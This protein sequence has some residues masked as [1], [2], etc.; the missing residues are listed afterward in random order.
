MF[1]RWENFFCHLTAQTHTFVR[2]L[3]H[4]Q[5]IHFYAFMTAGHQQSNSW[6]GGGTSA[7]GI[8]LGLRV[9]VYRLYQQNA[10]YNKLWP[11][12]PQTLP[13]FTSK[14]AKLSF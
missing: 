7:F 11:C 5:K 4:C 2:A 3:Q 1:K 10:S 12:A 6:G 14:W 9:E 13:L 8:W